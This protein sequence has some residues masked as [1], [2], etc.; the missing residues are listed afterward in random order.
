MS[1]PGPPAENLVVAFAVPVRRVVADVDEF[2]GH[3]AA[4]HGLGHDR[5]FEEAAKHLGE[6]AED[7]DLHS[8]RSQGAEELDRARRNVDG[9]DEFFAEGHESASAPRLGSSGLEPGIGAALYHRNDAREATSPR[10]DE[11]EAHEIGHVPFVR[12][13]GCGLV[14]G[15]DD[16]HTGEGPGGLGR[17]VA[18]EGSEKPARAFLDPSHPHVE[19]A[20]NGPLARSRRA[21]VPGRLKVQ[22]DKVEEVGELSPE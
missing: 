21:F 11:F 14:A 3:E 20:G 9:A 18:L 5:A 4:L 7:G 19:D 1:M 2:V 22:L 13:E 8:S 10:V 15:N 12:P 6:E 17:I 16:F